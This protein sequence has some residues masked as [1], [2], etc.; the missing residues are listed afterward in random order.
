MMNDDIIEKNMQ[1]KVWR[2]KRYLELCKAIRSGG[3]IELV[4]LEI[5]ER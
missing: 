1:Y 2:E 5:D 4:Y 3:V